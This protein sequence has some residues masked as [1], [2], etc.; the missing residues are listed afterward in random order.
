MPASDPLDKDVPLLGTQY[1]YELLHKGQSGQ[2]IFDGGG[3]YIE[4]L[5]EL[6][7]RG[8]LEQL[9]QK[10]LPS[11]GIGLVQLAKPGQELLKTLVLLLVK[12][13]LLGHPVCLVLKA[14]GPVRL[15]VGLYVTPDEKDV[16][17]QRNCQQC[18]QYGLHNHLPLWPLT[19][20]IIPKAGS[21]IN[22]PISNEISREANI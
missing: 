17:D 14:A 19:G 8:G 11:R 2:A 18:Y 1:L 13:K 16:K 3:P 6:L 15:L 9:V 21:E 7:V 4:I 22:S 12:L 10:R 20:R 5:Q